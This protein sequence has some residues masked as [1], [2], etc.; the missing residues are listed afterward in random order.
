MA[1]IRISALFDCF[2]RD[3]ALPSTAVVAELGAALSP[4]AAFTNPAQLS[5]WPLLCPLCCPYTLPATPRPRP[6]PPPHSVFPAP[7]PDSQVQKQLE[8]VNRLSANWGWKILYQ[9]QWSRGMEQ[10]REEARGIK[11][12]LEGRRIE[13]MREPDKDEKRW[14][15]MQNTQGKWVHFCLSV[16]HFSSWGISL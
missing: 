3:V 2:L 14:R 9:S 12:G 15:Q 4:H 11:T 10:L 16:V 5:G 6:S 8:L 1:C 7:A 13:R